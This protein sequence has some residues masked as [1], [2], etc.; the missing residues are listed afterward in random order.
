MLATA[1]EIALGEGLRAGY[2]PVCAGRTA[3]LVLDR[4]MG[5]EPRAVFARLALAALLA[6]GA[7]AAGCASDP[8]GGNDRMGNSATGAGTGVPGGAA[9]TDGG[10]TSMLWNLADGS[11]SL[12]AP[13]GLDRAVDRPNEPKESKFC[14]KAGPIRSQTSE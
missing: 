10:S 8:E 6:G 13:N 9:G 12:V 7:A 11:S 5:D 3:M 2:A 4:T 1:L 14:A